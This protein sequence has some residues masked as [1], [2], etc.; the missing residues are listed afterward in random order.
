MINN[1]LTVRLRQALA[2][3]G[4]SQRA[5]L[6]L[7]VWMTA[8]LFMGLAGC[9]ASG[10]AAGPAG[11]V[12]PAA[13]A[14]AQ[15]GPG[16]AAAEAGS[17]AA[18]PAAAVA[19]AAP[20]RKRE[21]NPEKVGGDTTVFA[22]GR[23]A[24]SFPAANLSEPE[25]TRFVIGNS[26][27][28]RN[29][30]EAPSS[31]RARDGL[32]PLF[33]A[34]SCGGCHIQ[35]GRGP[36]PGKKADGSTEEAVALLFRLSVPGKGP[37]G[38]P[39]PEPNYGEQFGNEGVKGVPA[40]GH[41]EITT[42]PVSGQFADGTAW[43]LQAPSYRFTE[44]GY[45]PM[46]EDVMVSPRLAPQ[47]I[48]MGLLEAIPEAEILRNAAE[49]KARGGAV[50]GQPNYVWDNFAQKKVIGRFGWKANVGTVA[51]QTGAAF[52]NDI[53]ITSP[54]FPDE[55]CMPGQKACI[56][57]PSGGNEPG[58]S[59]AGRKVFDSVVFYQA[60]LAPPA[61]RGMKDPQVQHGEKLFHE[62]GCQQCHRPSY[63]TTRSPLA[64][65]FPQYSSPALE[66]QEIW[67]YTDLLLHDMGEALADG[68]PDFEAN[69]RQWRTPPLWGI[70]M[71]RQVNGHT[72]LLHDGRA[73]GVLE[74]VLW[75]GGEAA[76]QRARV[77]A[78]SA[79]DREA[80]VS[81]VESL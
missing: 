62:A 56:D 11:P 19:V 75:H 76:E 48:G 23:M 5:G 18:S 22:D 2:F 78:M 68:R 53:G 20:Q 29:W 44:L 38:G 17:A 71:I 15:P 8:S 79:E 52:V 1:P 77:I 42:T 10:P 69:G 34:R 46:A 47:V 65:A 74:A 30:V 9:L 26:F 14:G 39:N 31:T 55:A 24:F 37:H 32:G 6:R 13:P 12:R 33:I 80:L 7:P 60:T 61:R 54:A 35:D 73:D 66:N 27:F 63:T 57:A 28:R 50:Q 43:Q 41:I 40:E 67:P 4:T 58:K 3:W 45:G 64:D 21:S 81:F 16:A 72:R 59:E 36:V 51:H 25:R 70:G 49:Q